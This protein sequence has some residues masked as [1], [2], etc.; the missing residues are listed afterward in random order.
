MGEPG[1]AEGAGS[2]GRRLAACAAA[3]AALY[4]LPALVARARM[5]AHGFPAAE[6]ALNSAAFAT[7]AEAVWLP[8]VGLAFLDRCAAGGAELAAAAAG[9]LAGGLLFAAAGAPADEI[10]AAQ[11]LLAALAYVVPA[12]AAVSAAAGFSL[13]AARAAGTALLLVLLAM[14]WLTQPLLAYGGGE[15]ARSVL[16]GGLTALSPLALASLP[17]SGY[18]FATL[19]GMYFVMKGPL[20]P[21]PPGVG[22]TI[23]GYAV[24]SAMLL[25]VGYALRYLRTPDRAG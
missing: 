12:A 25:C 21:Y 23:A 8:C 3:G 4:L 5:A 9:G 6:A 17:F 20:I 18:D 11:V 7:A 24:A 13:R 10:A 22:V 15:A 2:T 14:P 16:R 1:L 19:P